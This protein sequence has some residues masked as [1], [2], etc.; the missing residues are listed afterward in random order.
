LHAHGTSPT[1]L[2]ITF[3]PDSRVLAVGQPNGILRLVDPHT[4][5]DWA[6]LS[7]LDMSVAAVIAFSPD[8]R[9]LVTSSMDER[10]PAQVWDLKAM[11]GELERRGLDWPAEVLTASANPPLEGQLEV[12]LDDGGL[13]RQFDSDMQ[14]KA[15]GRMWQDCVN[16]LRRTWHA[17]AGENA[18]K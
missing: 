13:I 3:S 12:V 16:L 6:R 1:G 9:Y 11:R 2:G 17:A 10:S 18:T 15:A 14:R 4:A 5:N 8:Q 7:H